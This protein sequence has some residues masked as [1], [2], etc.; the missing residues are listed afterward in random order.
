MSISPLV[1]PPHP[2]VVAVEQIEAG[3]DR[4]HV[5]AWDGLAPADVKRLP[6]GCST[7]ISRMPPTPVKWIS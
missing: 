3:L 6:T 2:L 4:M 5:G 1:E 7:T